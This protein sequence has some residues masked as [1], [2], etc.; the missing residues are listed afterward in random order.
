DLD[1]LRRKLKI[2]G[3]EA[4]LLRIKVEPPL[5][6]GIVGAKLYD[7]LQLGEHLFRLGVVAVKIVEPPPVLDVIRRELRCRFEHL[8]GFRDPVNLEKIN[9]TEPRVML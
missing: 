6:F 2:A 5:R 9:L 8:D 4:V 7:L 3:A 1:E